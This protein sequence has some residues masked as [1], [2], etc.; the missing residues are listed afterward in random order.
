MDY[1]DL[2]KENNIL[3]QDYL[4][5]LISMKN[6]REKA[7]Y[8]LLLLD[9]K[10]GK[11]SSDTLSKIISVN[12]SNT[13]RILQELTNFLAIPKLYVPNGKVD[14][15]KTL[16]IITSINVKYEKYLCVMLQS[17]YEN[18]RDIPVRVFVLHSEL[19]YQS[20]DRIQKYMKHPVNRI[21]FIEIDKSAFKNF[22]TTNYWSIEAY[23]RLQ[24]LDLLPHDIDRILY[25]DVDV[26]CNKNIYKLYF[27]DFE[28]YDIIGCDD[29]GSNIPF[30]D[31]RD[32]IF[33]EY[34]KMPD[35]H[36]CN[37]GVM[38]WNVK[39]L[40]NIVN[41]KD[42]LAYAEKIDFRMVAP[43]QDLI[44]LVHA[45]RIRVIQSY[46]YDLFAWTAGRFL[47]CSEVI[48]NTA[49]LHYVGSKPWDGLSY[50][51]GLNLIW[52]SYAKKMPFYQE[53]LEK[54]IEESIPRDVSSEVV[55]SGLN[56]NNASIL[57]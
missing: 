11:L 8:Q 14:C 25:L 17:V 10:N 2:N 6:G 18:N 15:Q 19:N 5:Q 35:F 57:H 13:E 44:N 56:L 51:F 39:K 38:L 24:M 30:G 43:D 22:R 7:E 42:Y 29:M 55:M 28:G 12:F 4:F 32:S 46:I 26:I 31:E 34:L 1:Y 48:L 23:Y 21:E 3:Y 16:N 49:I 9:I 53:L 40:R 45:G 36:Y 52:W 54:V 37:S 41:L 50:S 47:P 33:M 27:A 20:M